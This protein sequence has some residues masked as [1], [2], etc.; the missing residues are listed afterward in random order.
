MQVGVSIPELIERMAGDSSAKVRRECAVFLRLVK[1][2]A[3]A[4][5]W[6][7]LAIAHQAGDRWS[8]EALGIGAAGDWDACLNAWLEEVGDGWNHPAGR[9]IVWRSRAAKSAELIGQIIKDTATKEEARPGYF[10]AL[11]F[12]P[13]ARKE[14]ALESI[15]SETK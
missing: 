5:L 6:R 12:Q 1:G 11:D 2:P 14:A 8:L 9:E 3:K 15:L 10:R 4:K 7:K 13:A